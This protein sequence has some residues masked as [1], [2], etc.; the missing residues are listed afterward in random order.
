MADADLR[1]QYAAAVRALSP[2]GGT[3]AD[4]DDEHDVGA[5]VDAVLAVRDHRMEQLA[6]GRATWKAKGEEIERDRDRLAAQ[7]D[8][9][10]SQLGQYADRAIANGERAETAAVALAR[11]REYAETTDYDGIRTRENVLRILDEAGDRS[12][13]RPRACDPSAAGHSPENPSDGGAA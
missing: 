13:D 11:I 8:Q 9:L 4:L 10:I 5:L 3:L 7:V 6:A 1:E 2:G 12:A